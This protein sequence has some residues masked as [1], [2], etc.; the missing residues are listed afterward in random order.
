MLGV[1][2]GQKCT[3]AWPTLEKNQRRKRTTKPSLPGHTNEET[4]KWSSSTKLPESGRFTTAYAS[5][6]LTCSSKIVRSTELRMSHTN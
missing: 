3:I 1:D 6:V 4:P 2:A 5:G